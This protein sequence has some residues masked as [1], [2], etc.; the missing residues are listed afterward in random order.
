MAAIST[1]AAEKK[2]PKGSFK[3]PW[4][5]HIR[6]FWKTLFINPPEVQRHVVRLLIYERNI[7]DDKVSKSPIM[8][9]RK[10]AEYM[11]CK[12]P[13]KTPNLL[14]IFEIYHKLEP[15]GNQI[16]KILFPGGVS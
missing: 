9:N 6:S 15:L 5:L 13:A 3:S 8:V 1:N 2:A 4:S 12:Q 14:N 16:P 11:P 7:D 10:I